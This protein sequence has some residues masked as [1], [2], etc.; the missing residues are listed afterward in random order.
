MKFLGFEVVVH[1]VASFLDFSHVYNE[2]VF[3]AVEFLLDGGTQKRRCALGEHGLV[4][5]RWVP[6]YLVT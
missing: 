3:G 6:G 2:G 5:V 4:P 1:F